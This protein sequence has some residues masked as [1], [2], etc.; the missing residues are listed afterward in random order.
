MNNS[1]R[2]SNNSV[3]HY[4]DTLD[5]QTA[6]DSQVLIDLMHQITGQPP[7]LW[8][9]G[10]LGFDLYHYKYD[11]GREG[12]AH[13]LGFYPRKGKITIY[14]MDGTHR[15]TELLAK[16]GKH[17]RTGYC[18]YIKQLS[19]ID[20]SVLKQILQQSYDYITSLAK[21]GPIN[22]ILWQSGE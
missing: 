11:S 10:T 12:D 15:H 17:S 9:A 22:R 13:V 4:L 1:T 2:Q 8:N 16:L 14:L 20:Q 18:L 6:Q 3:Q 21:N 5:Q 19:D 7:Q